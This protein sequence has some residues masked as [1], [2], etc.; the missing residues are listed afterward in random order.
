[1]ET[2]EHAILDCQASSDLVT[3]REKFWR[4]AEIRECGVQSKWMPRPTTEVLVHLMENEKTLGVFG[5]YV[6]DV[7]AIFQKEKEWV[8][9]T[10]LFRGEDVWEAVEVDRG[11]NLR[12]TT[13]SIILIEVSDKHAIRSPE[14]ILD[15]SPSP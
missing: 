3:R 6:V 2:E 13:T 10:W 4:D 14:K 1:M 7:F 9:P 15:V 8:P 11:M 5:E 12:L